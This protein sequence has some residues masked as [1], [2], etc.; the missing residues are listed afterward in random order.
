M[1]FT[2]DVSIDRFLSI[3]AGSITKIIDATF[4]FN[5]IPF[6]CL[7]EIVSDSVNKCKLCCFLLPRL[8]KADI[9][10]TLVCTFGLINA[11]GNM[12]RKQKFTHNYTPADKDPMGMPFFEYER[13]TQLITYETEKGIRLGIDVVTFDRS[14]NN[15]IILREIYDK[16]NADTVRLLNTQIEALER[17]NHEQSIMIKDLLDTATAVATA[18]ATE[19]PKITADE[20]TPGINP[21]LLNKDELY[22]LQERIT[23]LLKTIDTCKICLDAKT[24][25]TLVPCGHACCF[26]CA[27]RI[28]ICHLCRE[29]ITMKV[30]T[31]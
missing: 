10:A 17:R 5:A 3:K 25:A 19:A 8:D 22:A 26:V 12:C 2:F 31:Y 24:N 6:H 13:L 7:F 16:L 23:Q 9:K 29:P 1:L 27:G 15:D 14:V 20:K 11:N 30:K 28:T 18:T 4:Y 21:D